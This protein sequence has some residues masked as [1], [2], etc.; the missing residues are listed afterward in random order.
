MSVGGTLCALIRSLLII[1]REIFVFYIYICIIFTISRMLFRFPEHFGIS[2]AN[3]SLVDSTCSRGVKIYRGI[4]C[5]NTS[6]FKVISVLSGSMLV[7]D[8]SK[9]E[10]Y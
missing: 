5:Q 8:V 7:I 4:A 6:G 3:F 10:Q 2:I 1:D 9:D